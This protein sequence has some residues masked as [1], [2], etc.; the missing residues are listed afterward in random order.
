M[1]DRWWLNDVERM[2]KLHC[3]IEL[4]WQYHNPLQRVLK[5]NGEDRSRTYIWSEAHCLLSSVEAKDCLILEG[6]SLNNGLNGPKR[7][8]CTETIGARCDLFSLR[9]YPLQSKV[10]YSTRVDHVLDNCYIRLD[11]V[12][13][14]CCL[15]VNGI[16]ISSLSLFP[17]FS[18]SWLS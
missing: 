2:T 18:L 9:Q 10:T 4:L 12:I 8:V 16:Y 5:R 13:P 7:F 17:F 11:T 15:R 6:I 1:L 3:V 14:L